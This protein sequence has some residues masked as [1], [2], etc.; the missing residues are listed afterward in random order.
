M[1]VPNSIEIYKENLP[2]NATL[3]TQEE[4]INTLYSQMKYAKTI[5]VVDLIKQ[6]KQEEIYYKTDHH[7]TSRRSIFAIRKLLQKSRNNASSSN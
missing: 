1:L 4:D 5:A 7:M 3:P 2:E 6:S